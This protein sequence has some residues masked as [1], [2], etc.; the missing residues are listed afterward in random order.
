MRRAV[1]AVGKD[2]VDTDIIFA[3]YTSKLLNKK[4]NSF[5]TGAVLERCGR[6]RPG[7]KRQPLKGACG[8]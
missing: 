5:G 4:D 2:M 8:P 6:A 3:L 1:P 7:L